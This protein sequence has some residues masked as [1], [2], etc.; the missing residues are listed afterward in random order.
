MKITD[1]RYRSDHTRMDDLQRIRKQIDDVKTLE[2]LKEHMA[3]MVDLLIEYHP[4]HGHY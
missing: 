3:E 1:K 4:V 2:Q